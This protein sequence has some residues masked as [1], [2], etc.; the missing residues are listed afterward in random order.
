MP[1]TQLSALLKEFGAANLLVKDNQTGR[2]VVSQPLD[3][4]G[5]GSVDELLFQTDIKAHGRQQFTVLG[6]KNG[7]AQQPKSPYTT[8]SRLVPERID[9]FPPLKRVSR[10]PMAAT[11]TGLSKVHAVEQKALVDQAFE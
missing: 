4:D 7:A 5:N 11:S 10:R 6:L 2:F 1:A 3:R 8:F 9:D